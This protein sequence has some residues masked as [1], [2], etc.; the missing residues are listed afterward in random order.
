MADAEK[1][2]RNRRISE[3]VARASGES[4]RVTEPVK[5]KGE[6]RSKSQT[7]ATYRIGQDLI[8]RINAA[9]EKHSVDKTGLVKALLTHALDEL[10]A[11]KWELPPAEKKKLKI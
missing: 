2:D 9:A 6:R 4:P 10:E 8:D 7:A 3:T 1:Y 11:D 5:K